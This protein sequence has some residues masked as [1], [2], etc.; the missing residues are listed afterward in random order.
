MWQS[1]TN[2][3]LIEYIQNTIFIYITEVHYI[4]IVLKY[5]WAGAYRFNVLLM[6]TLERKLSK[7]PEIL[8]QTNRNTID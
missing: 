5:E 6:V 4:P 3:V 2:S 8:L 7:M 1:T